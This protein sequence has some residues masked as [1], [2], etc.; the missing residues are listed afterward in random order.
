MDK[1][2]QQFKRC[3]A[4]GNAIK[5]QLAD[6]QMFPAPG[7]DGKTILVRGYYQC[8]IYDLK[9]TRGNCQEFMDN[10]SDDLIDNLM[11]KM[12]IKP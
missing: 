6:N 2:I 3:R 12:G 11:K 4:N 8:A 10:S 9:C 5:K 1:F 7:K